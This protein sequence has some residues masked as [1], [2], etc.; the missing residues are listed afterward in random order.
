MREHDVRARR[1]K[2]RL[3]PQ[4]DAPLT[5]VAANV[6]DRAFSPGSPDQVW[7]ADITYIAT[8]EGWLYLSV[9]LDLF[10]RRV[11]GWNARPSLT[12]KGVVDALKMA[13][14]DRTARS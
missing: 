14:R 9:V 10:S 7:T 11:V 2:R 3:V 5:P 8:G 6:L 4:A 12:R 13:V 1:P